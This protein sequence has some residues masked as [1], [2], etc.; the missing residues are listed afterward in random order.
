MGAEAGPRALLS[1]AGPELAPGRGHA[2][3]GSR[4]WGT[5]HGRFRAVLPVP[6][7][8]P[9]LLTLALCSCCR[10]CPAFFFFFLIMLFILAV[11]RLHGR[12]CAGFR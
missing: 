3:A 10:F 11:L 4:A 9:P 2:G 12:A 6:R 5:P 8:L 1:G 7:D